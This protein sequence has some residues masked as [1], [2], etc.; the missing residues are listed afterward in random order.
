MEKTK[1]VMICGKAASGKDKILAG[2]VEREPDLFHKIISHT[3]R[4]KRDKEVEGRDYYFTTVDE[5]VDMITSNQMLEVVEFNRWFYGASYDS[6]SKDKINIGVFDPEGVQQI[7]EDPSIDSVVF[8]I[9]AKDKIRLLRY[10]GRE[11]SPDIE[12]MFRRYETDKKDF[13]EFQLSDV[14][15]VVVQ[16]NDFE[17]FEVALETILKLTKTFFK[18]T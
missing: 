2:L 17:E 15:Y 9:V 4:P 16:N 7:I 8:Y 6:L 14:N 3:T 10:L 12:E 1:I 11:S 5:M 18:Q 13:L